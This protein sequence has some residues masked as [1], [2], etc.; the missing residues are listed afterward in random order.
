MAAQHIRIAVAPMLALAA[1][2]CIAPGRAAADAPAAAIV[3]LVT[4]EVGARLGPD[5]TPR[6]LKPLD[7]LHPGDEVTTGSSSAVVIGFPDG[8]RFEIGEKAAA[9]IT[10][11][12]VDFRSGTVRELARVPAVAQLNPISNL[13][14]RHAGT[15]RIRAGDRH[16]EVTISPSH[17][18]RVLAG[19]VELSVHPAQG[20]KGF[21][22]EVM[23]GWNDT[24]YEAVVDTLPA[25]VPPGVVEAG[26]TYQ[27]SIV[28]IDPGRPPFRVGGVFLSIARS[29]AEARAALARTAQA[30]RDPSLF[31]LLA[32]ADATLGLRSEACTAILAGAEI[33]GGSFDLADAGRRLGCED[34]TN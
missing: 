27:W 3:C 33:A 23:E 6:R 8:R 11:D 5:E 7:L 14:G 13:D 2:F 25:V 24:V 4:G 18:G 17:G 22:V 29:K 1:V 32:A 15:D 26:K 12:A 21:R 30:S 20:F 28:G 9:T 31:V 10:A 19:Q 34:S 16:G